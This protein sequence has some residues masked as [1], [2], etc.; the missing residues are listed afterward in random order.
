MGMAHA[1]S[2]SLPARPRSRWSNL[3]LW[4]GGCV[5]VGL[6]SGYL[7][8]PADSPWFERLRKPPLNPPGWLFA[9]VWTTLYCLMG[10]AAWRISNAPPGDERRAALGLFALQLA[11]NF[12][13]SPLFFGLQA[14]WVALA[15]IVLLLVLIGVTTARFARIDP[16]AGRLLLPYVAWVTFATYLNAAFAILN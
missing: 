5:A 9:P 8:G 13:W 14:P 2:H 3:L 7:A 10:V 12:A 16:L 15:D 11:L 6:L 4:I 1:L